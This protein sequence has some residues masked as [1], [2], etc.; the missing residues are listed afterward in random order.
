MADTISVLSDL[1]GLLFSPSALAQIL[2]FIPGYL[3]Q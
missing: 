1:P 3:F 2:A